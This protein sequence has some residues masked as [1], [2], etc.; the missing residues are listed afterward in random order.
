MEKITKIVILGGGSAGWMSA[1]MLS[2]LMPNLSI[3][4]VESETI[5]TIGV[6]EAS[7]P[8]LTA[9]NQ[10]LGID[11][12]EFMKATRASV[13]LGIQFENWNRQGDSYMHAFGALGK[14]LGLTRFHHYWLKAGQSPQAFWD[15][16]FNYQAA[17]S[18]KYNLVKQIPNSNLDGLVHAYHFDA[19]L[20]AGF[21][22]KYA[23]NSGVDRVEGMV[24]TALLCEQSGNIKNIQ[25]RS[26]RVIE[27]DLFIDCS[28]QH[29]FLIE[30]IL[31]AGF[32][33][34]SHY[35]PCDR[36]L[37]IA[38]KK[39]AKIPPYTRSIARD[40]GWQWQI[41]LRHRVG[42]GLVYS[43]RYL[44]DEDAT[45]LLLEHLPS[46]AIAAPGLIK[47]KVGRR[48]KQWH[49]N[50][51]AVGLSGG[52]LEPLEST[53]IH[54]I[55][56]AVMRLIKLFPRSFDFEHVRNEFNAASKNEFEHIRDFIILH[57]HLN[58]KSRPMWKHCRQMEIPAAL[59]HK[60]ELFRESAEVSRNQDDLFAHTAWQQVMIGQGVMPE[61][62][63]PLADNLSEQQLNHF[64]NDL[65]AIYQ[66][67]AD[68]LPSHDEFL[69]HYCSSQE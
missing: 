62:Y 16:S 50:C 65:Y 51:V 34:W 2:K 36:A 1:A 21:L 10:A 68:A 67:C 47:F 45:A 37:A 6:G 59:R 32:E 27:G 53:G 31:G 33:D 5:G 15:Y 30:K 63:H 46:E 4:L 17:R 12:A 58:S 28:G 3:T 18:G 13:K 29:A 49:R 25:L 23:V 11:E 55:Q 48:K 56:S 8:P 69:K 60:I 66:K 52:F 54:L 22:Q 9:F 14:D 40:A 41:P 7:I 24:E 20:Y 44:S 61:R 38:S 35:L 19:G 57:Y 43:S 42:N 39:L 26:G 64:V